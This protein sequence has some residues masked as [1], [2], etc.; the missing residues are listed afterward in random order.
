VGS[1][2]PS[3]INHANC[4][5]T[6]TN[7]KIVYVKGTLSSPSEQYTSLTIDGTSSGTGILIVENGNLTIGGNFLWHGPII[8]TGN[9][10]GI[11][12]VGGGSQKVYGSVVVNELHNDGPN[13]LE[14]VVF[15]NAKMA[16]SK[17]ALD[18]VER[19]LSQKSLKTSSIRD[20]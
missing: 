19:L 9:N 11:R 7:A 5:G 8:M 14:G 16:Y 2:C 10:V 1:S 6:D 17:E 15:G 13:N 18:L 12:Y 3:A 20:R 4:W